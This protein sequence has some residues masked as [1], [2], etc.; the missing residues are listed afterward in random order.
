ME[1]ERFFVEVAL[2][3]YCRPQGLGLVFLG[4]AC[5]TFFCFSKCMEHLRC[6]TA[7]VLG[8]FFSNAKIHHCSYVCR[9]VCPILR[10]EYDLGVF[11]ILRQ[12]PCIVQSASMQCS[13][14]FPLDTQPSVADKAFFSEANLPQKF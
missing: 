1:I 6:L 12:N 13:M 14:S 8:F 4:N 7:K 2:W 11:Y 10:A 9:V 3:L 5:R